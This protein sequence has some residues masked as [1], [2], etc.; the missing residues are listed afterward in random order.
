MKQ[1][2]REKAE[3]FFNLNVSPK[4]EIFQ[5]RKEVQVVFKLSNKNRLVVKFN[6]QKGNKSYYLDSPLKGNIKN[7]KVKNEK[8]K[9]I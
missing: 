3:H 5:N 1:I 8:A 2:T 4:G 7:N 6:L 9:I